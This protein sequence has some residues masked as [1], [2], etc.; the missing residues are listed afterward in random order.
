MGRLQVKNAS[1]YS[2][3]KVAA[4]RGRFRVW[5]QNLLLHRAGFVPGATYKRDLDLVERKIT[6][7]LITNNEPGLKV[8]GDATGRPII[9][10]CS[11]TVGQVFG[12]DQRV[13]VEYRDGALIISLHHICSLSAERVKALKE[14]LSDGYIKE[15][16]LCVGIGMA[17]LALR[18]GLADTG[19]AMQTEWVLDR[20]QRFLDT[21]ISNNPQ[22]VKSTTQVVT[23]K[24]EEIPRKLLSKVD[25]L[26]ISMSCRVHTK[27][28]K[29]SK[30]RDV[31][32]DHGDAAGVYGL[33]KNLEDIN[34]AIIVSENVIE[35]KASATFVLLKAI[36]AELHYTVY[37]F[38]LTNAQSG[39]FENRLRYWMVA[40]DSS[41][42]FSTDLLPVYSRV[43]PRFSYLMEEFAE[44]DPV[45]SVPTEA[46]AKKAQRDREK[47]NSFSN[48]APL[49]PDSE[50]CPTIRADY[51]RRGSLDVRVQ[52]PEGKYR[53][54]TAKEHCVA[55]SAPLSLIDN[56]KECFAHYVLGQGID[57]N[58]GRGI[59]HLIGANLAR[60]SSGN[61]GAIG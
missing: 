58:Q 9:D 13:M 12:V 59:A 23:A 31:A 7:T 29:S 18:D 34:P 51:M 52:G 40:V 41:I 6:L 44:N 57:M 45:W 49:T 15:G 17:T 48:Q 16:T 42:P 39:S 33:L 50:S 38:S 14:H 26:Q 25:L 27:A 30:R 32:E 46:R 19:I 43:Y 8:T 53:M 35:A 24:M 55:K 56:L 21:A 60:L 22:A 37:E 5:I 47:G 4:H 28:S 20:D 11:S 54:L 10:I 1:D 36:L 2:F 3:H 61:Q